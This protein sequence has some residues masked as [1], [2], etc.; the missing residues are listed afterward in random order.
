MIHNR[1]IYHCQV[2]GAVIRHEPFRVPPLCCGQAMT[3]AGE[4]TLDDTFAKELDIEPR[5]SDPKL[6][7]HWSDEEPGRVSV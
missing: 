7:P 5:A 4:E 3:K 1:P 6:A 2:C